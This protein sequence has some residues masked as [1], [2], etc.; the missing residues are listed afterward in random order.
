M[1]PEELSFKV[2]ELIADN[3]IEEAIKLLL[4]NRELAAQNP[5]LYDEILLIS[6]D[7][8][9]YQLDIHQEVKS[10]E[11]LQRQYN[12]LRRRLLDVLS[13]RVAITGEGGK[14]T[15]HGSEGK[16]RKTEGRKAFPWI[17]LAVPVLI[18]LL[19]LFV[20]RPAIRQNNGNEETEVP[21]QVDK[22]IFRRY[23]IRT[24]N[25][26]KEKDERVWMLNIFE[27][28]SGMLVS[29]QIRFPVPKI[30]T[31]KQLFLDFEVKVRD[32]IFLFSGIVPLGRE[33]LTGGIFL[34]GE[35]IAS[36]EGERIE[37]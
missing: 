31:D 1:L 11:N 37:K 7:W 3:R 28:Y 19:W 9:N 21:A 4:E 15:D 32:R 33:T 35:R 26:P 30:K 8:K 17:W 24:F 27:D 22:E 16:K 13:G 5:E 36:W 25:W 18:V 14:T 29:G 10:N 20:I 23:Q 2:K 6:S 12:K 34:D